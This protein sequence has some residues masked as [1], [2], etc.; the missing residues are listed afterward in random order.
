MYQIG[1]RGIYQTN[2]YNA[3]WEAK[4][5]GFEVLE[6]HCNAPKFSPENFSKNERKKSL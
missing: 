2:I 1:C 6:L 3:I 4:K 5:F